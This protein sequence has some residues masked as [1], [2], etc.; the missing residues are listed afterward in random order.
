MAPIERAASLQNASDGAYAGRIGHRAGEQRAVNGERRTRPS[1]SG[2]SA[3]A[4]V[5]R[6]VSR[7][8]ALSDEWCGRSAPG[9]SNRRDPV[10][11]PRLAQPSV[12]PY[13]DSRA[14]SARRRATTR[15]CGPSPRCAVAGLPACFF[16]HGRVFTIG[17]KSPWKLPKPWTPRTRPPLLGKPTERVFHCSYLPS[18]SL[19]TKREVTARLCHLGDREALSLR[20]QGLGLGP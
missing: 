19:A 1:R 14:H 20:P 8:R 6:P 16:R 12:G 13:R 9:R 15:P 3:C 18:S 5:S 2:P 17:P 10:V 4:G 11:V 7:S